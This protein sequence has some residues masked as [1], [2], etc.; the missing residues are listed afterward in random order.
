M[1]TTTKLV[2]VALFWG[3]DFVRNPSYHSGTSTVLS[4]FFRIMKLKLYFFFFTM[5]ESHLRKVLSEV[6]PTR[7]GGYLFAV[8]TNSYELFFPVLCFFFLGG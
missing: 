8:Q 4:K 5:P 2:L 6:S 1:A 3:P 7:F